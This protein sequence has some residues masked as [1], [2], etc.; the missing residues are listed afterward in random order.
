[1]LF[2]DQMGQFRERCLAAGLA[3]THQRTV[4]YQELA[5]SVEH[6]SPELIFERVG[7]QIPAI[8]LGT[9]YKSIRTF[10]EIGLIHE[11]N[12]FTE[13]QRWDANL[14]PHHHLICT[15]CKSVTDIPHDAVAPVEF[16]SPLPNE[17]KV[18]RLSLEVLG[19]CAGCSASDT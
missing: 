3:V 8:S 14:E 5:Q 12:P 13:S 16:R 6:P 9:I 11:V 17:F 7:R 4:I 1:M 15:R 2:Q 18:Q 19:L 10:A